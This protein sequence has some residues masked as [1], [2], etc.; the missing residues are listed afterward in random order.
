MP[1]I[2]IVDEDGQALPSIVELVKR[3]S[4]QNLAIETDNRGAVYLE[5]FEEFSSAI[6]RPA[7]R[8]WAM[9][10]T[11]LKDGD[12]FVC[13]KILDR[14]FF[15]VARALGRQ[16][17]AGMRKYKDWDDRYRFQYLQKFRAFEIF[18]Q[19]RSPD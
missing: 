13:R 8:H 17:S 4:N 18:F 15:L 1:R 2:F 7:G 10:I 5:S 19:F 3:G 12:Y 9:F 6:I 16:I 11:G 14:D